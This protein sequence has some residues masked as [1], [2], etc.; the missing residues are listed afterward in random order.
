MIE[1]ERSEYERTSRKIASLARQKVED[2]NK[3]LLSVEM[4]KESNKKKG[5]VGEEDDETNYDGCSDS[6]FQS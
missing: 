3:S 1:E 2:Y 5:S 6:Q 4:A